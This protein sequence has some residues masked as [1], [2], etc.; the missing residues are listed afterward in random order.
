MNE[1]LVKRIELLEKRL[2][3]QNML[4][5]GILS[6]LFDSKLLTVS[7]GT[8]DTLYEEMLTMLK[9]GES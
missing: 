9:T 2:D 3:A 5:V 6:K 7:I 8:E 4:F 1:E